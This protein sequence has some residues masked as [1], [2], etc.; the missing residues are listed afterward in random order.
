MIRRTSLVCS[1]MFSACLKRYRHRRTTNLNQNLFS[2]PNAITTTKTLHKTQQRKKINNGKE[3]QLFISREVDPKDGDK[4]IAFALFT[5]NTPNECKAMFQN[6]EPDGIFLLMIDRPN[7]HI[8]MYIRRKWK[9][10]LEA[11][12]R[13]AKS[14]SNCMWSCIRV[15]FLLE[16]YGWEWE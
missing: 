7:A 13:F 8:L 2:H 3:K 15:L 11:T 4:W 14:S 12:F 6:A 9:R 5:Q 1:F 16:S 10:K